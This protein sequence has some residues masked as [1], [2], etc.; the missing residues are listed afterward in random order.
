MSRNNKEKNTVAQ[1]G[2]E[3][4]NVKNPNCDKNILTLNSIENFNTRSRISF[5]T[6]TLASSK[7]QLSDSYKK[8][9]LFLLIKSNNFVIWFT[10]DHLLP[11]QSVPKTRHLFCLGCLGLVSFF[12]FP[13]PD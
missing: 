10:G 1:T 13:P 6:S 5:C 11:T 12:S 4:N 2:R 3:M 9:I 7:P 8:L